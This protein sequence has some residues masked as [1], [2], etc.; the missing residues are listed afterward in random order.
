ML[1]QQLSHD[2]THTTVTFGRVKICFTQICPPSRIYQKII[3]IASV[4][5]SILITIHY[6]SGVII[7]E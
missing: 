2:L 7:D 1:N 4:H 5:V 3:L 6:K